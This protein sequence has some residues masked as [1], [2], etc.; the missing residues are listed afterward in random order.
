[1]HPRSTRTDDTGGV[2]PDGA[3]KKNFSWID[4]TFRSHRS[5]NVEVLCAL[6]ALSL[7]RPSSFDTD[8]SLIRFL[9]AS[10]TTHRVLVMAFFVLPVRPIAHP[11][12]F[13]APTNTAKIRVR[14]RETA[15]E[16]RNHITVSHCFFPSATSQLCAR[17]SRTIFNER[18]KRK[19]KR[20]SLSSSHFLRTCHPTDMHLPPREIRL[21]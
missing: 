9:L 15:A 10:N 17:T 12:L 16:K 3:V 5:R 6:F 14:S 8:V 4:L 19:K 7:G 1:M 18:L 2:P 11:F 20:A 21:S 13:P